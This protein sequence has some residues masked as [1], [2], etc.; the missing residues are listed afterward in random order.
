[1]RA[2]IT[3]AVATLVLAA[4]ARSEP[5]DMPESA[6]LASSVVAPG[7]IDP[8]AEAGPI[9]TDDLMVEAVKLILGPTML[10]PQT[11]NI[12]P[13]VPILTAMV[14]KMASSTGWIRRC[15]GR[16]GAQPMS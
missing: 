12:S 6:N 8:A 9:G 4:C 13:L 1:M 15:A 16:A 3:T 11:P 7:D 2:L 5:A 14:M 10:P